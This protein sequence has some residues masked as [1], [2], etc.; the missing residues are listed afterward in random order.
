MSGASGGIRQE[1]GTRGTEILLLK[2]E[3]RFIRAHEAIDDTEGGR[4]RADLEFEQRIRMICSRI[5]D[6]RFAV[7][8]DNKNIS[9]CVRRWCRSAFAI[10]PW[11][12][13]GVVMKT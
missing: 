11:E 8:G 1:Q 3:A 7:R 13:F 12:P 6:S 2:L 5:G 4:D 10:P 9:A